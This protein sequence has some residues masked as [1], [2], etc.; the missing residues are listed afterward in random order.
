MNSR[1]PVFTS[2]VLSVISNKCMNWRIKKFSKDIF[3][4]ALRIVARM[5]CKIVGI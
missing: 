4:K 3:S 1:S 5:N 2:T